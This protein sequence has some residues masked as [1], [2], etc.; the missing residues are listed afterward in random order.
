MT[1]TA[2]TATAQAPTK[3]E[4]E[5]KEEARDKIEAK[6]EMA[7]SCCDLVDCLS[8]ALT[9]LFNGTL[10]LDGTPVPQLSGMAELE[11]EYSEKDGKREFEIEIKW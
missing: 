7:V 1:E 3:M 6:E 10:V 2:G 4:A 9:S 8:D 11:L 5:K